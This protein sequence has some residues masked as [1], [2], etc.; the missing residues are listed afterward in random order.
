MAEKP[1]I[2]IWSE[3]SFV[4]AIDWH[5]RYRPDTQTYGLVKEL[6]EFLAA[7]P[8][9]LCRGQR[10]RSAETQGGRAGSAGGLQRGNPL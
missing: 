6:R 7:Q 9:A 8:V 1:E 4:P 10:R 3:T 5:T 2:V